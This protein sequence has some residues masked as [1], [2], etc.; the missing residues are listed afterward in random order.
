M[1]LA[2]PQIARVQVGLRRQD[3]LLLKADL[4]GVAADL[5]VP[6]QAIEMLGRYMFARFQEP[7]FEEDLRLDLECWPEVLRDE[8]LLAAIRRQFA[9]VR[10]SFVEMFRQA[11][12]DG[13]LA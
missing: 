7:D 5:L 13:H 11:Q 10:E 9:I 12:A 8:R 2:D 3:H 1:Q 6:D 4:P